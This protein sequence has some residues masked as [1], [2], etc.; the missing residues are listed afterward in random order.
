[1]AEYLQ[2]YMAEIKTVLEIFAGFTLFWVV[3]ITLKWWS[4]KVRKQRK[5]E[6]QDNETD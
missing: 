6:G 3:Y 5:P 2:T 4:P 1:M